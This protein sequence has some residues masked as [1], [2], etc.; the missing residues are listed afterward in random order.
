TLAGLPST[1]DTTLWFITRLQRT[2]KS[3]ISSPKRISRIQVLLGSRRGRFDRLGRPFHVLRLRLRQDPLCRF[4]SDIFAD[5]QL[6]IL[7][8]QQVTNQQRVALFPHCPPRIVLVQRFHLP[9]LFVVLRLRVGG[10][11]HVGSPAELLPWRILHA[12]DPVERH[13]S[14]HS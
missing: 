10:T 3:S 1:T 5:S 4:E 14:L 11:G 13:M 9:A 7:R 12:E 8:F 2:Q 6:A